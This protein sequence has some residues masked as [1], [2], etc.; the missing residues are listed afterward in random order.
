[1][2]AQNT[3]FGGDVGFEHALAVALYHLLCDER[4]PDNPA[5][6][7]RRYGFRFL[8]NAWLTLQDADAPSPPGGERVE[9]AWIFVLSMPSL[10]DHVYWAVVPRRRGVSSRVP[11]HVYGFN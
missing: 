5:S 1:M 8:C 7:L 6:M 2:T 3:R 11:V 10:S 4:E 9:D